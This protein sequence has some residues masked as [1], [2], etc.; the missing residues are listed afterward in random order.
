MEGDRN[1]LFVFFVFSIFYKLFYGKL[2]LL[3]GMDGGKEGL[4]VLNGSL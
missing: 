1:V 3:L 4:W 2:L